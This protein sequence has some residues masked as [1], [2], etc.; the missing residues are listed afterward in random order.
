[1]FSHAYFIRLSDLGN[2]ITSNFSALW[3]RNGNTFMSFCF[4]TK[5]TIHTHTEDTFLDK[6]K[7][8]FVF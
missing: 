4:L 1:M 6:F 8:E 7:H 3:G 2:K 5:K